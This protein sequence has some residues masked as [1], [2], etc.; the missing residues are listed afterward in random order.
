MSK[1]IVDTHTSENKPKRKFIR[2]TL[3]ALLPFINKEQ[4]GEWADYNAG[5]HP[6]FMISQEQWRLLEAWKA[7]NR[8]VCYE[9]GY[10]FKPWHVL[11]QF[12]APKHIKQMLAGQ[13]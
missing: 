8:R 10:L 7:G 9:D 12:L 5:R 11:G 1:S 4:C 13:K 2:Q 6:V 3:D